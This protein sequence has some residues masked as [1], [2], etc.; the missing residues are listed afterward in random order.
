[1]KTEYNHRLTFFLG[2]CGIL[3]LALIAQPA[4]ALTF[5][6]PPNGDVV[7]DV[8]KVKVKAGETLVDVGRRHGIGRGEMMVANPGLHPNQQLGSS[9][10]LVIPS[11]FVLPPGSREGIVINL[12][13]FRLYYYPPGQNIVVT[14]AV[15]IGREGVDGWQTPT[16]VTEVTGK[17]KDPPWRP[18]ESVRKEAAR[19]GNPIPKYFPPGKNNPLGGYVL[20][21]GWPAYLIH[22]TNRPSGVGSRVSAGCVRMFPEGIEELYSMVAVGT[23]VRVMNEP[24]KSG[25]LN[26]KLYFE[27]HRPLIEERDKYQ[28]D[29]AV[30]V[31]T[32]HSVAQSNDT[33]IK[34][35]VVESSA[36]SFSGVPAVIGHR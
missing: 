9:K 33:Y 11:Q 8:K 21:L 6:L 15:G 29:M 14:Q 35:S 3:L 22:G 23:K 28:A 2:I 19:S 31:N 1:M 5:P 25:W 30:V 36:N 26:G 32:V 12:A 13:E 16:G 7:G 27:A 20:R 24:F 18:P 4:L 10:K 34:W 17:Q